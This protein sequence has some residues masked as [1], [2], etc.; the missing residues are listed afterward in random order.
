[1]SLLSYWLYPCSR[2]R[3]ASGFW[4]LAL[5]STCCLARD[6]LET[7]AKIG[8]LLYISR[9][10][11]ITTSQ[12]LRDTSASLWALIYPA[13]WHQRPL[14][15]TWENQHRAGTMQVMGGV[16]VMGRTACVL[17]RGE[18]KFRSSPRLRFGGTRVSC[19]ALCRRHGSGVTSL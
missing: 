2:L 4:V 15:H 12:F 10:C 19:A 18:W 13:M 5:P 9:S 14:C 3:S 7:L 1:M 11:T 17:Q 6:A 16:R 8:Y